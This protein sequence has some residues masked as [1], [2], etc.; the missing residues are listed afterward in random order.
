LLWWGRSRVPDFRQL[1]KYSLCHSSWRTTK[2]YVGKL[3]YKFTD[4]DISK[5]LKNSWDCISSAGGDSPKH[6]LLVFTRS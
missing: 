1:Q 5:C 2:I 3:T 6:L 4:Q